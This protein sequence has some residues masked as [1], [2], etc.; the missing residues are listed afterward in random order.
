MGDPGSELGPAFAAAMRRL[1]PFEPSPA[2][3]AAVSGGADS[4]AL[5]ILSRD[6]AAERGGS[7]RAFVVD[8]GLRRESSDEARMT[9]VRLSQ[10]GIPAS[11]LTLKDLTHGSA[12]AKR[13]RVMRYLALTRACRDIGVLHLLLGHHIADQAETL[14]MR[15]L[16]GSMTNGLAAMPALSETTGVRLIRPLLAIEPSLLRRFLEARDVGWI[17]DPSNHDVRATR[18]RMRHRLGGDWQR[19][20]ELP[21][22]LSRAGELRSH[23]EMRDATELAVRAT[24]RPEGFAVLSPGRISVGALRRLLRAIGG[25]AYAPSEGQV[26]ELAA[27]PGPATVAGVRIMHAG[28]LGPGLLLVREEAAVMQPLDA[29]PGGLWDNRFR[30][31]S[32]T[33][34]AS[35]AMIGKLGDDAARFRRVSDLP[36]VVLRTLPAIRLGK[37]LGAVPHLGY[38]VGE[39]DTAMTIMFAPPNPVAGPEFMA[40]NLASW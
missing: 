16:Q 13:A 14:A 25:Q 24:I 3:A 17:E 28:R 10:L 4:M 37:V 26:Y 19:G 1:G 39:N 29:L 9:V 32:K 6:W 12:L 30:L 20:M 40:A 15:V 5:A 34:L 11:V 33:A 38:A 36:S 7:S 2:L 27:Q 8:H 22:A 31:F 21:R 18:N 23:E 35:G